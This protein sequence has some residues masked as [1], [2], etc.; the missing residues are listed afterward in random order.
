MKSSVQQHRVRIDPLTLSSGESA[1]EPEVACCLWGD[2]TLPV[3]VLMGGISANRWA[4]D[5]AGHSG[6]W[7][8]VISDQGVLNTRQ[9]C[10]LTFEY[11]SLPVSKSGEVPLVTTTDQA[12]VLSSLQ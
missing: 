7:R 10:F 1:G 4:L 2:R 11:L 6:W 8:K 9:Y 3:V 12:Q 5:G